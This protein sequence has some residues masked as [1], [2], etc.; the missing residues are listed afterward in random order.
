MTV[1][2]IKFTVYSIFSLHCLSVSVLLSASVPPS[3]CLSHKSTTADSPHESSCQQALP[4]TTGR[5]HNVYCGINVMATD[6]RGRSWCLI[7]VAS[8]TIDKAD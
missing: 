7:S 6:T 3:V 1:P 2:I 8:V 5:P 4:L